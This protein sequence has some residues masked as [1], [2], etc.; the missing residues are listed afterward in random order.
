[1]EIAEICELL[2]DIVVQDGAYND[3]RKYY[4]EALKALE[5]DGDGRESERYDKVLAK[6][7]GIA[8]LF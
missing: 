3:G 1:M 8:G 7:M 4:K 2:G 5:E 6:M